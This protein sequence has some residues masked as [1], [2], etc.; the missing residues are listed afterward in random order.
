M[1][2]YSIKNILLLSLV[3][4]SGCNDYLDV[5]T[6]PN[7]P[8]AV[9]VSLLLPSG[10][11]GAAFANGNELNRFASTVMD[12]TYGAANAPSAWDLYNTDGANFGNQWRFEI[13]GGALTIFQ[14]IINSPD[15]QNARSYVGISKI[16]K[17]YVF[18]IATDCWGDVPYS[19]ALKGSLFP[20]PRI[21]LQEDMYKGNVD[22][23]IQSLFDLIREG[24]ADL[25]APSSINPTAST[26]I[27]YGGNL[28]NW[29][30][31]GY[32]LMLKLAL[33]ISDREPTLATSIIN[34]VIAA[35]EYII[36]NNQNLAV[37][38]GSSVGSQSPIYTWTY[39]SLF[40]NDMMASTGY[41]NLLSSLNDPRLDLFITKPTGSFV[42]VE[43]GFRG[44]LPPVADRSKWSTTITGASGVGPIRLLTNAQRAFILAEAKL[45]LPSVNLPVGQTPQTLFEEG[46]RASMSLS[47]LSTTAI[48]TYFADN[49]SVMTLSGSTEEQIE[50]IITQKYIA[51]TGNGLEA[52]NDYRRTG[53]PDF[54]EHLN[55][56]G[57]DGER[58]RRC[59]YIDQEVQRNPNFTPVVTSEVRVWW[60]ID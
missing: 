10:L 28:E 19:D 47:G 21:D 49:A 60:D 2:K 18:S 44:T 27:V 12:Y 50:Q 43:N 51:S 25:N 32:T 29:K 7:S 13:Y 45:I 36:A 40:Q 54:P 20:Q 34:E 56:V 58:P 38:F 31:A 35:D 59:Q 23:G 57:I 41:V 8:T 4:F 46:I 30:R 5:N 48:D 39:V 15:A 9:P 17:A 1:K 16:M 3:V 55:A 33:Q 6:S 42:T 53:Y 22:K 52:W 37:N 14:S 26:D 24:I 11:A